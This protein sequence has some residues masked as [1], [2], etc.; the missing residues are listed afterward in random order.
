MLTANISTSD[1]CYKKTCSRRTYPEY[2]QE[3]RVCS[4]WSLKIFGQIYAPFV[5]L[6][7]LCSFSN[8]RLIVPH[9]AERF[10]VRLP[11]PVYT[12]EQMVFISNPPSSVNHCIGS[13]LL[14][15]P[16][17]RIVFLVRLTPFSLHNLYSGALDVPNNTCSQITPKQKP[18]RGSIKSDGV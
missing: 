6:F 9:R 5:Y 15:P 3:M 14:I 12:V 16:F 10:G 2:L 1:I 18:Q 13:V 4:R 7:S 17:S 11:L 8:L